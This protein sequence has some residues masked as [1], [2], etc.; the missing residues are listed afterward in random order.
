MRRRYMALF[1]AVVSLLFISV[2]WQVAETHIFNLLGKGSAKVFGRSFSPITSYDDA[3]IPMQKTGKQKPHYDPLIVARAAYDAN[4]QRR[5]TGNDADFMLLTD[6]L[7]AQI[8]ET[9]STCTIDYRYDL[10]KYGQKAPWQS[11]PSQAML[12]NVLAA[13]AGMQRDLEIYGKA[14]RTL[15]TLSPKFAGLS[16]ALSD[17]S[18]W[19]MQYPAPE[20]YYVL[21]GMMSV[22]IELHSYYEQTRDPLA[23]RLYYKG[24]NALKQKLPEFDHHGYS[25]YDLK[26]RK[27][28]RAEHQSHIKQLNKL[29]EFQ[30][31]NQILQMRNRWQKADSYPVFW[32]MLFVPQPLRVLTFVV[33]LFAMWL[34]CYLLLVATQRKEP[35]DSEHSSS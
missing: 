2:I 29:L 8:V 22:L 16:H 20:P 26:G 34:V 13:R 6:W 33:A 9:D 27:A 10:P 30:E 21:S 5:L 28:S 14:T 17:S 3:G 25:R 19:Y 35:D 23:K 12:M 32:Q 15:N 11:A 4:L 7:L 24:M 31:D 1:S 18:Y